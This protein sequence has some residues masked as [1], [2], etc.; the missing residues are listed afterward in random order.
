VL[1]TAIAPEWSKIGQLAAIA[2]IRTAL[3]YFL[4]REL[5]EEREQISQAAT[6]TAA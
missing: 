3:N 1:E 4:G 2:T 5:R 6:S